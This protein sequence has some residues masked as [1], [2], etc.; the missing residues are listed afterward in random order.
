MV[1]PLL[2]AWLG[3][4]WTAV[5]GVV[6]AVHLW[7]V[8]VLSG[9]NRRWHAAHVLMAIG[10]IVM[11]A[12]AG[13]TLVPGGL[14]A[15]IFAAAAAGLAGVLLA[16]VA[17]GARV[18]RLWLVTLVDLAA[19]ACMFVMMVSTRP[20]WLAVPLVV[21]FGLQTAAWASGR[22]GTVLADGGL[23]GPRDVVIGERV[24]VGAV[25][26]RRAPGP[27][28]APT[29]LSAVPRHGPG[30]SSAIRM[31]L[32]LMALGMAYMLVAMQYGTDAS[33]PGM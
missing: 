21:W 15:A 30:H 31:T 33:M 9:R 11:F 28:G 22:L 24:G 23:G 19:M 6:V 25:A 29:P 27:A 7:H 18:G 20:G 3:L 13:G 16:A 14:G 32:S 5:L 8:A 10:M 17:Q 1:N 2:P 26:T 4:A 12:P